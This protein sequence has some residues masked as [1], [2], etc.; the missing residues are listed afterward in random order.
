MT[1]AER[2][3]I[4]DLARQAAQTRAIY[5]IARQYVDTIPASRVIELIAVGAN[6]RSAL[7]SVN[8]AGLTAAGVQMAGS[9][10][11]TVGGPV[12]SAASMGGAGSVTI[13][14]T[15]HATGSV[16]ITGTTAAVT[17]TAP[18][19]IVITAGEITKAADQVARKG[20]AGLKPI[21]LIAVVLVILMFAGAPVAE[22]KLP[23]EAQELLTNEPGYIALAVVIVGAIIKNGKR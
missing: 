8:M 22:L 21:T 10:Q 12:A 11:L 23:P 16:V 5:E 6:L 19:E 15:K 20:F 9:G 13:G 1:E 14:G 17:V 18:P 7:A 4:A 2:R 3:L